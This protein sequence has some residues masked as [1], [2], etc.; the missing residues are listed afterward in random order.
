M[1]NEY[2]YFDDLD[3]LDDRYDNWEDYC[4]ECTEYGDDYSEDE[5]GNLVNNCETCPHN[6]WSNYWED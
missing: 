4:Y 2:E 1:M 5:D 3:D 6:T